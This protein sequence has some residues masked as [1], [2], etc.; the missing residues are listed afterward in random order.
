MSRLPSPAEAAP[1]APSDYWT[2]SRQPLASLV[3]IAP[4]LA[5]YEVGVLVLG[6][7]AVRN[8]ADVW[9]RAL[10]DALDFGQYFL[11]PVL[12]V[13][14]LLA[15]HHTTHRPW[16]IPRGVLGGMVLESAALAVVLRA[17]CR[18]KSS[19]GDPWSAPRAPGRR[20]LRQR[21]RRDCGISRAGVYEEF[22]FRLVLLSAILWFARRLGAEHAQACAAAVLITSLTFSIAHYVGPHGEAVVWL[23]RAFW[24]GAVFRFLAGIFFSVLFV[25]RGFGIAV[26][27]HAGYDILVKLC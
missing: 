21:A 17:S 2:E 6:P 23:D 8:G 5:I 10:L 1:A 7:R 20:R 24:F 16:R 9:L 27:A 15:W 3:F 14:I 22:L 4:V 12:T 11:L 18:W 25:F 19:S 13:S 26:G